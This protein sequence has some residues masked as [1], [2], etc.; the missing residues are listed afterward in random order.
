MEIQLSNMNSATT[1]S[2][3]IRHFSGYSLSKISEIRTIGDVPRD[4]MKTYCYI[5]IDDSVAA[6]EALKILDGSLLREAKIRLQ[7]SC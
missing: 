4:R 3:I 1:K 6:N 7:Q 5:S 2:D